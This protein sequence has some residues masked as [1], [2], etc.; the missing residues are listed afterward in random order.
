MNFYAKSLKNFHFHLLKQYLFKHFV[1]N[2]QILGF[3]QVSSMTQNNVNSE[4]IL[5]AFDF[6]STL[7]V[8]SSHC[9]IEQ[10]LDKDLLGLEE[11]NARYINHHRCWNKRMSDVFRRLYEN[12]VSI[13]TIIDTFR[14]IELSPGTLDLFHNLYTNQHHIVIISDSCDLLIEECF[15]KNNLLNYV[16]AIESNS[17]K[18]NGMGM[19]F[20][21]EYEK[22]LQ[23]ECNILCPGNMCKGLV[24]QRYRNTNK[25]KKII[26]VGDG[27]NDVCPALKLQHNDYV[28]AKR[29]PDE[30][31][32]YPLYDLLKNSY[33][34]QLKSQLYLWNNMNDVQNILKMKNII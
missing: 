28:F 18:N 10:L 9:L 2:Y 23:T 4:R 34:N 1:N 27:D 17:M 29:N 7:S 3:R 31:I 11:I 25:Y 30:K 22:P 5:V 20:I 24:I 8:Q 33:S 16:H 15:R 26:F 12:K 14:H 13:E 32:V 21:E 6:D 19:F